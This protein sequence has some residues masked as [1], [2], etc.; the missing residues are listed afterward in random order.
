VYSSIADVR[1]AL[2]PDGSST[3]PATAAGLSDQQVT[4]GIH[5]ADGIVDSYI[6]SRYAIA[7]DATLPAVAVSPVR[8]WS[9]TIAAYLLTL[10]FKRNQDVIEDDPV[11]QRY[12]EVMKFLEMVRAGTLD[13]PLTPVDND[14]AD[15]FVQNQYEGDLFTPA[16]FGLAPGQR[17]RWPGELWPGVWG[18]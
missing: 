10:T 15:V 6:G 16:H 8:W 2:A 13:L 18:Y 4:D 3:D 11:R 12:A 9:R 17:V 14:T 7:Q 5:E 1:N